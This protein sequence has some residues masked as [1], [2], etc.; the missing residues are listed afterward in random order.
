M[1]KLLTVTLSILFLCSVA[2][3]KSTAKQP[4][5]NI[6]TETTTTTAPRSLSERN[7]ILE[8][9]QTEYAKI[10]NE[11]N[12]LDEN[13]E[14]RR[15]LMQKMV[16]NIAEQSKVIAGNEGEENLNSIIENNK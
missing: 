9:L 7:A 13:D 11:I 10:E 3:C 14:K 15:E 5:D 12:S 8:D 6:T 16:D 2:S 1:K 4:V